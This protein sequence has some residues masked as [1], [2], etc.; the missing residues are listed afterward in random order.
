[1]EGT[2]LLGLDDH[3]EDHIRRLVD[4]SEWKSI[5]ICRIYHLT[6]FPHNT[7]LSMTLH[8]PAVILSYDWDDYTADKVVFQPKNMSPE[9]ASG[10]LCSCPGTP[11][12]GMNPRATR[13]SSC[14]QRVMEKEKADGNLPGRKRELMSRRFG[15]GKESMGGIMKRRVTACVTIGE[16]PL[17]LTQMVAVARKNAG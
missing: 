6:P 7:G 9:R 12:M 1:M 13:C 2:I 4:F 3:T 10:A 15:K 11:S 14:L 8:R 17:T 16:D 5:W